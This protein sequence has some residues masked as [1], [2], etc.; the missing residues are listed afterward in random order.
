MKVGVTP[1]SGGDE[2]L[3]EIILLIYHMPFV[4]CQMFVYLAA[5]IY[6]VIPELMKE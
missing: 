1:W 2:L 3:R 5:L 6:P 4:I